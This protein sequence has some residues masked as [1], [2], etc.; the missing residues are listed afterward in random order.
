VPPFN[1]PGFLPGKPH[2]KICL[3]QIFPRDIIRLMLEIEYILKYRLIGFLFTLFAGIH[4]LMHIRRGRRLIILRI[5][6]L[7]ETELSHS[8]QS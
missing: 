7:S 2:R 6:V 5:Y 1:K 8:I 3:K 4:F